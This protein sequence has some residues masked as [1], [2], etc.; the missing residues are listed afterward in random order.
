LNARPLVFMWENFGPMH[1]DRCMAVARR[2]AGKRKVIGIELA[3]RSDTYD[4]AQTEASGFVKR[5][6]FPGTTVADV[7]AVKLLWALLRTSVAIGPADFFFCRYE[8]FGTLLTSIV[9]RLLGRRVFTMNDSKF[10]DKPRNVWKELLKSFYFAPYNGALAASRRSGEYLEFLHFSS[11][12]IALGYDAISV[13]RIREQAAAPPEQEGASFDARHFTVV[14]RM[15]PKK[16]LFVVLEAFAHYTHLSPA[17]RQLHFCGTGP[18]EQQVKQ[19]AEKLGLTDLVVFHGSVDST[20]V[21][22]I[23]R[24]TL[25]LL[26][27]ST[28]EQFGLVIPEAL[29]MGVPV[30]ASNNCGACDELVRSGVNGFVVEPDNPR[31]I[32]YFMNLLGSDSPLWNEMATAAAAH[33]SLGDTDRFVEACEKLTGSA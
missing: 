21:S 3:G 17:P 19:K 12:S 7:S 28:E 14:A 10:D 2:Y 33:A 11:Q 4:W 20:A 9:L 31:G 27:L 29:S 8:R 16:N 32:A 13:N 6:L 25:A 15:V 23:L 30:I 1:I 26:L 5:T 18:L 24:K 22:R